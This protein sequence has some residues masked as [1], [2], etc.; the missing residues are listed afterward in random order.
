MVLATGLILIAIA[1]RASFQ[2]NISSQW[3]TV[4]MAAI[5]IFSI[6]IGASVISII[7]QLINLIILSTNKILTMIINVSSKI[8]L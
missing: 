3:K 2:A 4:R 8:N 5:I 7:L 6:A 1:P